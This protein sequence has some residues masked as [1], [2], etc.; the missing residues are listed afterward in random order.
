MHHGLAWAWPSVHFHGVHGHSMTPGIVA[1]VACLTILSLIAV[2][3]VCWIIA[4]R[5]RRSR[6]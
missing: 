4:H 3:G 1:G 6:R 2:T 5:K